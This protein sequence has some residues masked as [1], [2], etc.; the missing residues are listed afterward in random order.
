MLS[1]GLKLQYILCLQ[2]DQTEKRRKNTLNKEGKYREERRRKNNMR[3]EGGS[4][5]L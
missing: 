4:S 2:I 3:K 1:F 5:F